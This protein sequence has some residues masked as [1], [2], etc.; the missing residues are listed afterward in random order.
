MRA[1]DMSYSAIL[2]MREE[3]RPGQELKARVLDH[4]P[5]EGKLKLSVKEAAPNPFDGAERRHPVGSRRQ[6]VITGKYAGGVFCTLQDGTLCMCLYSNSHYD[7][8]FLLGANVI[9]HIAQYDY[10]QRHIYGRI[11][12]KW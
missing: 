1:P 3:Y 5:A 12:S 2:D 11:V 6:A 7:S 10:R 4:R 9:V 8:D